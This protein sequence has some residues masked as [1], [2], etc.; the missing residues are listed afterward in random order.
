MF[1]LIFSYYVVF[2]HTL[3]VMSLLVVYEFFY[4][5]YY[6]PL[7]VNL[8]QDPNLFVFSLLQHSDVAVVVMVIIGIT[9]VFNL[10]YLHE[11]SN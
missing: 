4:S 5:A 8:L 6:L 1:S 2:I 9:T 11:L 10:L 7:A 3:F